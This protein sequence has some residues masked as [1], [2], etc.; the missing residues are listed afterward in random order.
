MANS[1]KVSKKSIVH[2][3]AQMAGC[4]CADIAGEETYYR[5]ATLFGAYIMMLAAVAVAN[6]F[7]VD[8]ADFLQCLWSIQ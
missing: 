2:Y 8:C 3:G 1:K 6:G 7:S 5:A 4:H